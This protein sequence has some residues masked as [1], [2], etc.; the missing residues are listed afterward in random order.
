MLSFGGLKGVIRTLAPYSDKCKCALIGH[1]SSINDL[2]YHPI[3]KSILLSASK[4][5][6][7]R[8]WNI[9]T[10]VCI[11]VFGGVEGHRDEVLSA[12]FNFNGNLIMSCSID[13]YLKMWNLKSSKLVETIEASETFLSN[14]R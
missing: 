1:V 2:R 5:H 7:L 10:N 4:D 9:N 8:L 3:K 14:T 11:A 13:H 6:T 12:D